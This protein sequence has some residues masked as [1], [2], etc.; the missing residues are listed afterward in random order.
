MRKINRETGEITDIRAIGL[1]SPFP[2][3]AFKVLG[4]MKEFKAQR[5]L[6]CLTSFLGS[7]GFYVWPTYEQIMK[8]SGLSRKSIRP[9]LNV[10]Q[11]LDFVEIF[12]NRKNLKGQWSNNKYLIK[13][14]CY[15][16]KQFNHLAARYLQI[17]HRC[18]GCGEGLSKGQFG[19]YEPSDYSPHW[20]CGGQVVPLGASHKSV[21]RYS[22]KRP[23]DL[24]G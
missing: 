20:G 3:P 1:W 19:S 13:T 22:I 9:A 12:P 6:A 17:S 15:D 14:T 11:D 10:L 16:I 7:N 2:I 18:S 4:A 23:T 5:L 21:K 8:T 24:N